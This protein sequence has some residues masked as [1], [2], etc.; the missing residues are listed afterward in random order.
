MENIIEWTS[1]THILQIN[2]KYMVLHRPKSPF[3]RLQTRSTAQ[4]Q[5]DQPQVRLI[6]AQAVPTDFY[7]E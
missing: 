3:T 6:S 5:E 1:R 7:H 4:T 2:D